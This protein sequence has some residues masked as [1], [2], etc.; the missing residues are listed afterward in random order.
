MRERRPTLLSCRMRRW[1]AILGA[2]ALTAASC[3]S[4]TG[5]TPPP[6]STPNPQ[7]PTPPTVPP[8]T[9]SCPT[10]VAVTTTASSVN[11]T[12]PAATTTGGVA[13][14]TVSCTRQSG[15]PFTAGPTTVQCT[16]V[17]AASTTT[18]CQFSVTVAYTAPR[19]SRTRLLAFGDSMTA[20]E[21]TVPSTTAMSGDRS[22]KL[23]IVPSASYPSQLLNQLRA[24]YTDQASALSMVN[25]GVPG[26]WAQDGAQRLP[27]I[28]A[29]QR[30]EAVLL[31]E[32]YNDLGAS[33]TSGITSGAAAIE[34]MAKE[35]RNR[36]ARLFLATLPPPGPGGAKGIPASQVQSLNERIRQIAA[37][38]G[39]VLVD[40][41]AGLV[42][43]VPRYVGVDGLHLTEAGYQ[44]LAELFF[45]AI[46]ADLEVR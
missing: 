9:I 40:A 37:G 29:N 32:G 7:T 39:A 13:P 5:P 43:D 45:N 34:R 38:E 1:T 14:V 12:F 4:P 15:S 42:V 8:L 17:D 44:K 16:A 36:G 27:N 2:L 20:G 46:R 6:V 18:S 3:S 31:L 11:V 25:S 30:P 23:I 19:I 10:D 26:E 21:I 28:L 24:R 41:Y 35:I 33:G 22:F